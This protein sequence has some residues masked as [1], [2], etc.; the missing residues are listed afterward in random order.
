[1]ESSGGEGQVTNETITKVTTKGH[2]P[3]NKQ[4]LVGN[5]RK[6]GPKMQGESQGSNLPIKHILLKVEYI[7]SKSP[8]LGAKKNRR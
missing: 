4:V 6:R 3:I 7:I 2:V 1:M 5:R 8:R